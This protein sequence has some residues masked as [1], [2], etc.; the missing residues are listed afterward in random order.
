[1]NHVGVGKESDIFEALDPNGNEIVIKIH[2]LG[3]TSFRAVRKQRDY[4]GNRGKASWLYMSRLAAI[5]EYAFMQALY[6]HEF[7]TPRPIAQNRHV[8][9]MSRVSGF[10]MAQLKAGAVPNDIAERIFAYCMAMLRRLAEHGLIHCDF[11]EFNLMLGEDGE[12]ITLIDFPQMISTNHYNASELFTRDVNCLIKFFA[13]K[14]RYIPPP[15][16]TLKLEDIEIS[17]ELHLDEEVRASGFSN[18][19]D[20]ELMQYIFES[21]VAQYEEGTEVEEENVD[22]GEEDDN[23]VKNNEEMN[24][25]STTVFKVATVEEEEAVVGGAEDGEDEDTIEDILME[26]EGNGESDEEDDDE[27]NNAQLSPRKLKEIKEQVKRYDY[28]LHLLVFV[29]IFISNLMISPLQKHAS[30]RQETE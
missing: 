30:R 18:Q 19:E 28:T 15:E 22:N 13:M 25:A 5:K 3:R 21:A 23:E 11:N 7:P 14:M 12:N 2:R 8:V 16:L 9:A 4:M 20:D 10:P 24:D 26:G 17:P 29:T 1:M 27:S 6:A